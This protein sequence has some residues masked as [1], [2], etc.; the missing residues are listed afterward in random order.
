LTV[1]LIEP[2][3]L[4]WPGDSTPYS[5]RLAARS[6]LEERRAP[7]ERRAY[8]RQRDAELQ[9][10]RAA[11]LSLGQ[12]VSLVDLSAGGALLDSPVPLRPNSMLGLEIVGAGVFTVVQFRVLRCEVGELQPARTT[13]RGA[14]E[15]TRI[16]DL[17]GVQSTSTLRGLPAPVAFV[18]LDLALKHLVERAGPAGDE[19]SLSSADILQ[20]LQALLARATRQPSDPVGE[21]LGALL[22]QVVPALERRSG[23]QAIL[24]GIES[25]L[26][27]TVP[28][29]RLRVS[30]SG[31]TAAESAVK[32]IVMNVPRAAAAS[33]VVSIDLPRGLALNDWQSRLLKTASRLIALLQRIEPAGIEVSSASIL[34]TASAPVESEPEPEP[35]PASE[36]ASWQKI[37]VRYKEGQILK[38]YSQDFHAGRQQFTLWPAIS[39]PA[40]ERVIVPL[41]RLKAVFFV[42]DFAGD[43]TYVERP[44]AALPQNGRRI[45]VT[46]NDD[47]VIVGSTLNYRS[48]GNGFFVIPADPRT[49]NVRVFVVAS[50]VR[51]VRFPNP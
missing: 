2:A 16:L 28:Q 23:L 34:S 40:H 12:G 31:D 11:R 46:L 10:V 22:A 21:Q 24:V 51:Q 30:A 43:P 44:D 25:Q 33:P 8:A 18:G 35:A 38:G 4:L 37:V 27:R 29:A 17:P 6:S 41:A 32:A 42:R 49:N 5:V 14:C 48:D 7:R 36:G 39:S 3:D 50:A 47:E 15:F 45:E 26:R 20:A 19:G 13:Y 1:S 9:W